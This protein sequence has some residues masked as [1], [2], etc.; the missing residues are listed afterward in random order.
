MMQR[1]IDD[2]DIERNA[3]EKRRSLLE[4]VRRSECPN[5]LKGELKKLLFQFENVFADKSEPVG[6]CQVYKPRIPLNTEDV[7]YT[8]QYPIPFKM[9]D[10]MDA[11]VQDFAQQ[12]IIK[13]STSPFN[14]PTIMVPKKDGG[15]RMV[16]DFRKLNKHVITDPHPLPR[17]Q[18]IL[19]TL[20]EAKFFSALDLLHGFYN[21]E[22]DE[23]D[24]E[25]TAFSTH[26]G[27]F[28]FVRLPMG[29]KNS[30]AIFND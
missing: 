2:L 4:A 24:R 10:A 20:G 15:Y 16:V 19:E 26:N 29:L 3:N 22:L 28:E 14:S 6:L 25:K 17:I 9:R 5:E 18:Q 27:H 8:P 7:V 11:A 1:K 13:P 30:P 12:G 21:L 23:R